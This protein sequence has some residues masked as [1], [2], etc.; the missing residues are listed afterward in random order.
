MPYFLFTEFRQ[1]ARYW[2]QYVVIKPHGLVT[3][4]CF[5]STKNVRRGN[6]RFRTN[7]LI[8]FV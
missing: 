4:R 1:Q 6:E 7:D 3:V 5:Y 8:T 2:M